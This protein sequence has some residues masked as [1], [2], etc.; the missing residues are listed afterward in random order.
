MFKG[1]RLA[2]VMLS[3]MSVP[4]TGSTSH[5]GQ[6]VGRDSVGHVLRVSQG[7]FYVV[8]YCNVRFPNR[9]HIYGTYSSYAQAVHVA[10]FIQSFP[11]Y[12]A[13]IR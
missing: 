8:V 7:Q 12:A 2:A 10:Q 13:F 9:W 3:L 4:L 6:P 1:L 11:E 5:A